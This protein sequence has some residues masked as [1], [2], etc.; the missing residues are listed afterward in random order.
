MSDQT[1]FEALGR[2]VDA[3][4]R[5]SRLESERHNLA[6]DIGRQLKNA[7]TGS[8]SY[9]RKFDH[10]KLVDSAQQLQAFNEQ[11]EDAIEQANRYAERAGKPLIVRS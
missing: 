1:D 4:E 5:V 9:I 3:K 2:Y 8:G 7:T 6:G 11:L 10:V